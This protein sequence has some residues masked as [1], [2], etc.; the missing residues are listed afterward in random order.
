[1]I[2]LKSLTLENLEP[3]DSNCSQGYLGCGLVLEFI[4]DMNLEYS[5]LCDY[6]ARID[7]LGFTAIDEKIELCSKCLGIIIF[8][9][10]RHIL[11]EEEL[12]VLDRDFDA[13]YHILLGYINLNF[14]SLGIG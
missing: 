11:V 12:I 10:S 5:R 1:M 8:P 6:V 4:C 3:I 9:G 7:G 2:H 13:G 14:R